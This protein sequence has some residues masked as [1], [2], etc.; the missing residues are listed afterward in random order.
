MHDFCKLSAELP[1]ASAARLP[2]SQVLWQ[3]CLVWDISKKSARLISER[4][5]LKP[6]AVK[7][8]S[9]VVWVCSDGCAARGLEN[10]LGYRPAMQVDGGW[11]PTQ[12]RVS[13]SPNLKC[14]LENLVEDYEAKCTTKAGVT[15]FKCI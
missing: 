5:V 1:H 10:A 9:Q 2:G 8:S 7:K 3:I 14:A 4:L 15:S 6:A 12:Q 11:T 13:G